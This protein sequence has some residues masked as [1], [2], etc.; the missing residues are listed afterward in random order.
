MNTQNSQTVDISPKITET[1]K[2]NKGGVKDKS[3]GRKTSG[4]AKT[5]LSLTIIITDPGKLLDHTAHP[6]CQVYKI[7]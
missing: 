7:S 1:S 4:Y 2:H 5:T 6:F 3:S